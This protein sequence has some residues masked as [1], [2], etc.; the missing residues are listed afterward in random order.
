M[1]SEAVDFAKTGKAVKI[2][3][4]LK[5][6]FWPDFMEK[7]N[8]VCYESKTV[9]GTLFRD[10]KH[11]IK[12]KS[13]GKKKES[14]FAIDEELVWPGWETHIKECCK[15]YKYFASNFELFINDFGI[16]NEF[17]IYS[18]NYSNFNKFLRAN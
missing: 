5:A 3:K 15:I 10:V 2:H 6:K 8:F 18:G 9:L 1:H 4:A 14:G 13:I 11:L 7:K 12:E 17:E 16:K